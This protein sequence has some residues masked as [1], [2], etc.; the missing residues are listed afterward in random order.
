MPPFSFWLHHSF[1]HEQGEI[2]PNNFRAIPKNPIIAK[3][4]YNI[5]R[6][7]ELG[8]GVRNMFKYTKIY[9][10][11]APKLSWWRLETSN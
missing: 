1:R 3:F 5:G 9:S 4:F 11:V 6:A 2:N 10:G 7:D 8:S